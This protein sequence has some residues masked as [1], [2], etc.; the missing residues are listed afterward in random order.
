MY[1]VGTSIILVPHA[2]PVLVIEVV[3]SLLFFSSIRISLSRV[4]ESYRNESII[5][6]TN[7]AGRY[8]KRV[9]IHVHRL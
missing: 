2:S 3:F 8:I 9:F 4:T 5:L 1:I 6:N 7:T